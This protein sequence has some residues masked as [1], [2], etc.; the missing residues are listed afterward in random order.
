[1][2][3]LNEKLYR[4]FILLSL[5]FIATIG[6]AQENCTNG[7]DDDG[8]GLIDL[9]DLEDCFCGE[10]IYDEVIADFEDI[11]CCPDTHFQG[12]GD[13]WCLEDGWLPASAATSDYYNMCDYLGNPG[14]IMVP[15]PIPSGVGAIGFNSREQ[16]GTCLDNSMIEG[17]LYELSFFIG[18]NALNGG[19]TS[20]L[21]ITIVLYGTGD[22]SNFPESGIEFCF[23][24][25]EEWGVITEVPVLGT[26]NDS[27]LYVE[28][29]FVAPMNAA[30]IAFGVSCS[31]PWPNYHFIDDIHIT[32]NYIVPYTPQ[33]LIFS[34]NCIDGVSVELPISTGTQFQWYL[35]G[36]AIPGATSN[37]Y[38]IIDASAEGAYQVTYLENGA[39]RVSNPINIQIEPDIIEIEGDI[40]ETPCLIDSDGSIDISMNS[41]NE[42]FDFEWS[43]GSMTEDLVDVL[44]GTYTV[45]VTDGNGCFGTETFILEEPPSIAAELSGDCVSGVTISTIDIPGYSY[46]WYVDGNPI[47]DENSTSYL[48]P[49]GIPGEYQIIASMGN[50]CI[51][52]VPIYVYV[53][54]DVLQ[55][56]GEVLDALCHDSTDGSI[57]LEI[58]NANTPVTYSWSN[59]KEVED[60]S[61][62]GSGTYS[63]TVIDEN[64][65]YG[66][67]EFTIESPPPMTITSDYRDTICANGFAE[68]ISLAI[69]GGTAPYTNYWSTGSNQDTLFNISAGTYSVEV[70]DS[71]GCTVTDTFIIGLFPLIA[72]EFETTPTDCGGEDNGAIDLTISNGSSSFEILWSNDSISEDV[73]NLNAG[74][75]FV[76]VTDSFGCSVIDSIMVNEIT[77]L[78]VIETIND[79]TCAGEANGSINLEVSGGELPYDILWSNGVEVGNIVNLSS[80][81]YEVTIIDGAGCSWIESFDILVESEI[82]IDAI[83]ED[84][85]CYEEEQG[86]IELTV[87]NAST[88]YSIN[89]SDGST[90]EDR[91]NLTVGEYNYSLVDSFGCVYLDSFIILEGEEITYQSILS[92]PGCNGAADGLISI[93]PVTGAFPF[94]YEWSNGDTLNQI[95]ELPSG[96]YFLTISDDNDCVKLDTFIL[97]ESSDVEV[98]E[99][100]AHNLCYGDSEGSISLDISGGN[101]PYEILWNNAETSTD[102]DDLPVGDY[103]VTVVDANDCSSSYLYSIFE[104]DS[105][106][107]EDIITLPLCYDGIGSI[108]VQG[109]GGT[110]EYTFL[111]STGET[112]PQVNILP[113]DAYSVTITD[114]NFCTNSKTYL[115]DDIL[116]IEIITTSIIDPSSLNDDGSITLEISGGTL[117]YDVTWDN[118]LTGIMIDN[119]GV[120][121]FTATVVDANACTQTITIELSND[122]MSVIGLIANN[123][124][125]G[126]CE[127]QIDLT[128]EG[129]SEPYTITWS[130]GQFGTNATSLCNGEHQ[131]TITNGLGEEIISEWFIIN[132]PSVIIIDGQAYDISCIDMNDG[133][134]IVTPNGGEGPFDFNWS[135]TMIGDSIGNLSPG[136]YSVTIMDN[137]GCSE[138]GIYTIEDIPLIEIDIET[139]PYDCENLL[140]TIII[141]GDNIYDYPYFLNGN[142]AIP[143]IQNEITDLEPGTYQLSY[144]INETCVIS[145]ETVILYEKQDHHFEL[146]DI[147]FTVIEG[148][149]VSL[150]INLIDDPL[151]SDFTVDWSIINSFD[152]TLTNEYGQCIEVLIYAFESETIEVVI[153]DTDGCETVVEAKIIVEEGDTGIYIPNIF[154]PNG[155]GVNDEF[156]IATNDEELFIKSMLIFDRWGNIV[157]SQKQTDLQNF[158]S[159]NGE[160]NGKK[161]APNVF[162]YRLEV[163]TGKG[164]TKVL[165][166]DL[167]V[168]Y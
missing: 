14:G 83:V 109:S 103:F 111:W 81:F 84:N 131:A 92:E 76:T 44:S 114:M 148:E 20:D 159:W 10:I 58:S 13:D 17:E 82:Y 22:C 108:E 40:S 57:D 127:G 69:S 51:A 27:W 162:V 101:Q 88:I 147:D 132:S 37:P 102:I 2:I 54:V 105:L 119:L 156:L 11:S 100:I 5:M 89:W 64:G 160:M 167:A 86:S 12:P 78:D 55:V 45:T 142:P 80:G 61:N 163:V 137:N 140:S 24:D 87:Q 117:P 68:S 99:T 8:D 62:L 141:N 94:T 107:I 75:Y 95:N 4:L 115:I 151:L 120:G 52:S 116:E 53:D 97:S 152:C 1:M 161:V 34:G 60:L 31:V 71:L 77:G 41:S 65:C 43:N 67:M 48:I 126:D 139:L 42:P 33:D 155:D 98:T 16:I 144:A 106:Q 113:G 122:P 19:V 135:N 118:G 23:D 49:S 138:S 32:G 154:S 36:V 123:L 166:G 90:D 128:V 70:L 158:I 133:S 73:D 134:I 59:G 25:F 66:E 150:T 168:V 50:S 38:L 72:L 121:T 149:E 56:N 165:F 146:S 129:G 35:D 112:N 29:V 125:Y 39:C 9:L 96:T 79:I 3:F 153:T 7:I 130:N 157:F 28:T 6:Y 145:I 143:N 26:E 91:Y 74:L 85:T 124:C 46:Q 136:D 15:L 21:D 93:S 63:V 18:F 164:E 30:A 47:S 104:P 110:P